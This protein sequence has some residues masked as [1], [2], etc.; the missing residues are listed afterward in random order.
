M[1]LAKSYGDVTQ[2]VTEDASPAPA[3]AALLLDRTVEKVLGFAALPSDWDSYGAEPVAPQAIQA[4]V[5]VLNNPCFLHLLPRHN[6]RLAVFPRRD[7]GL[8]FD[9][10]GGIYALEA[11]IAA[12]GE[13]E[14]TFF[15]AQN[16]VA[17]EFFT[18]E[19]AA[20]WHATQTA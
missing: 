13:A 15:D 11:T 12:T 6:A 2:S 8:Q 19:E 16:E 18:L 1:L 14:Y 7:G 20:D 9:V 3:G 17:Q 4:A 10:D 5:D